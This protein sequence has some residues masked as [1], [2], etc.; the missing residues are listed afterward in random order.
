M[1]KASFDENTYAQGGSTYGMNID[2]A[3]YGKAAVGM[4]G[5]ATISVGNVAI[6]A[7]SHLLGWAWA[8]TGDIVSSVGE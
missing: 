5:N 1:N 7:A 6:D 2:Y 4:L 3:G 8:V